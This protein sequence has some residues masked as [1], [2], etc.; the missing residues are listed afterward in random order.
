[1]MRRRNHIPFCDSRLVL[2][3]ILNSTFYLLSALIMQFE[4]CWI[5]RRITLLSLQVGKLPE[6][7]EKSVKKCQ[8]QG[9]ARFFFL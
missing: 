5:Y 2:S 8:K 3:V 7:W 4:K 6:F 1:M 9:A